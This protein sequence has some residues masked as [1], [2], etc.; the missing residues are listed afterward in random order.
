MMERAEDTRCGMLG[1]GRTME[2]KMA[3]LATNAKWVLIEGGVITTAA[4]SCSA[5]EEI[6]Y[7]EAASRACAAGKAA[8]PSAL[9]EF[10]AALAAEV[11][12]LLVKMTEADAEDGR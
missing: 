4:D 11:R 5:I 6:I 2:D 9:R 3:T 1:S 8:F 7:A 12:A 10:R